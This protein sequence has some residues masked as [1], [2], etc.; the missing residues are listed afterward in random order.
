MSAIAFD[1][2]AGAAVDL[3]RRFSFDTVTLFCA[4]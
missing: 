4:A 3:R 2:L 1:C